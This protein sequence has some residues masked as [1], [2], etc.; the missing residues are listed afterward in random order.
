MVPFL[1]TNDI[2]ISGHAFSA[3]P[4]RSCV[5][6]PARPE[7]TPSLQQYFPY[8]VPSLPLYLSPLTEAQISKL[9]R[10]TASPSTVCR[11]VKAF[12]RW[13]KTAFFDIQN[14][15]VVHRSFKY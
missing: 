14:A 8:H 13:I 7:L 2:R 10:R 15:P 9:Q 6:Q 12:N 4:N 3:L 11:R 1:A 5:T